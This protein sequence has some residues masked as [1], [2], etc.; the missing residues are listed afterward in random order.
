MR[1]REGSFIVK[2]QFEP[3]KSEGF[4][5]ELVQAEKLHGILERMPTKLATSR[6]MSNPLLPGSPATVGS[7][8]FQS[9]EY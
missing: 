3:L 7:A 6:C 8:R 9:S 2:G 4:L 1:A 5:S